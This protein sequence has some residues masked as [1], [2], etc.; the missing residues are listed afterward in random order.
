MA[1][2]IKREGKEKYAQY[3]FLDKKEWETLRK[4]QPYGNSFGISEFIKIS[5]KSCSIELTYFAGKEN[6]NYIRLGSPPYEEEFQ[7]VKKILDEAE[8]DI[9]FIGEKCEGCE[10]ENRLLTLCETCGREF[11][12]ECISLADEIS[13]VNSCHECI[14]DLG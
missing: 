7:K 6:E 9:E 11:C 2:I 12:P 14:N 4:N 3:I 10:K 1:K 8:I 5:D 13:D